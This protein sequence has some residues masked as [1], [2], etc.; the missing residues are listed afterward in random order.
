MLLCLLNSVKELTPWYLSCRFVL[1]FSFQLG[2]SSNN[3][4]LSFYQPV[5]SL[6]HNKPCSKAELSSIQKIDSFSL[7]SLNDNLKTNGASLHFSLALMLSSQ[8]ELTSRPASKWKRNQYG[9][10]AVP[11]H[12]QCHLFSWF[13]APLLSIKRKL[14]PGLSCT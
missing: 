11:R 14:I 9:N 7:L 10:K 1:V 2:I 6:C 13:I 5:S 3:F 12:R 4:Y 8:P